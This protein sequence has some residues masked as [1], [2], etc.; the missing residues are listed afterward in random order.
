LGIIIRFCRKRCSPNSN[1][2]SFLKSN[3]ACELPY[4]RVVSVARR[5][6]FL[7]RE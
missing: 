3:P 5:A 6:T 4:S 7:S 1:S 2:L